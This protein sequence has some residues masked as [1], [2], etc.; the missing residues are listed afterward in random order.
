MKIIPDF[1]PDNNI[2]SIR[3]LIFDTFIIFAIFNE[4]FYVIHA[5]MNPFKSSKQSGLSLVEVLITLSILAVLASIYVASPLNIREGVNEAKLES[6]VATINSAIASYLAFNG[7]LEGT[8]NPDEV[9]AKLKSVGDAD[10]SATTLGLRGQF[11]DPR[12]RI[13]LQSDDEAGSDT[14]R[15]YWDSN[16][17]KFRISESGPAGVKAFILDM[18]AIPETIGEEERSPM[19]KL[20]TVDSWIWDYEDQAAAAPAGPS[21]IPVAAIPPSPTDPETNPP[22]GTPPPEG[23]TPLQAPGFTVD[24]GD[25]PITQFDLNVGLVNPNPP[26]SSTLAYSVNYGNWI[27][28]GGGVI[29][30][31]PNAIVRAQALPIDS[32]TWSS[33]QP[34]Q[35]QYHALPLQLDPPTIRPSAPFF[36]ELTAPTILATLENPNNPQVSSLYYRVSGGPWTPY[37]A[38]FP[39]LYSDY[40]AGALI[41]ARAV[42]TQEFHLTSAL[43]EANLGTEDS[44]DEFIISG[45][46]SGAFSNV[47]GGN[48]LVTNL[49]SG[50]AGPFLEWGQAIIPN[51]TNPNNQVPGTNGSWASTMGYGGKGFKS[52]RENERFEIGTISY[53]NGTIRGGTGATSVDL[54]ITIEI[55]GGETITFDHTINMINSV[56]VAGDQVA[57]ADSVKFVD[58]QAQQPA[59]IGDKQY[60]LFVE[61]GQTDENGFASIDEFFVFENETANG[62]LFGRLV[63]VNS[64]N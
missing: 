60:N 51:G 46:A 64:G 31:E 16:A 24:S 19:M 2:F 23:T 59:T 10:S 11:L 5:T 22:T 56:N 18:E 40:Q 39:L 63:E 14:A 58:I 48:Q 38:P 1:L 25:F 20:A 12:T 35:E 42:P 61:F 41:E 26:G 57:S 45:S 54:Q 49:T 13:V 15:A 7:N 47:T 50:L 53:F 33:S 4:N 8:T 36:N 6:D 44:P 55:D 9:L 34:S 62:T 3:N 27:D 30:V 28:Y 32:S 37:T 52:V 29:T 43:V 17:Q 21:V